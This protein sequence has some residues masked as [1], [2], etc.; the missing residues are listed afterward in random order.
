VLEIQKYLECHTHQELVDEYGI[1]ITYHCKDPLMILNYGIDS[2]KSRHPIVME[3]RAL[4]LDRYSHQL[5]ARGFRRF[6]NWGQY[7]DDDDKENFDFNHFYVQE[8]IDG[9]LVLIYFYRGEWR[10]NTRASFGN[11][12]INDFD[13]IKKTN[14]TWGQYILSGMGIKNVKELYGILDPNLT[15]VCEFVSPCTR[16]IRYYS[17]PQVYLLSA[18]KGENELTLEEV[19][20]IASDHKNLFKRP[21]IHK[22]YNIDEIEL[23]LKRISETDPTYEGVVIRDIN[24]NRFKMKSMSYLGLHAL[25]SQ[26]Q[27]Q[28]PRKIAQFVITPDHEEKKAYVL[29][30]FPELERVYMECFS[31]VGDAYNRLKEIWCNNYKIKDQKEFALAIKE[32]TKFAGILFAIRKKYG[33]NQTEEHLLE[34]WYNNRERITRTLFDS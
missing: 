23:F 12:L 17:E 5:V 8:K 10:V 4:V 34:E 31:V 9:S 25:N 1:K 29:K 13:D 2:D 28:N 27:L 32:K 11:E 21:E 26:G 24:N 6:F 3:C 15:Y 14:I 18:Y 7:Q 16:V 33:E 30:N 20:K 19:D 22:I